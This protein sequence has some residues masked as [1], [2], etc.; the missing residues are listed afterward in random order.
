VIATRADFAEIR[1]SL[2]AFWGERDVAHLHHPMFIEEFGDCALVV[3]DTDGRVAAYLL[4]MV[5]AAKRLGYVHAVAVRED[6]RGHGLGR[7]LYE[8]FSVLALERGCTRIKAITTPGNTESVA[9]HRSMGM[10]ADPV[11]DYSGPGQPRIVFTRELD[12]TRGLAPS[13]LAGATVRVAT[14]ADVDDVLAFWR[15]AAEDSDR[16]A[17]RREAVQ[18]LIARDPDAL[19]LVVA[20][21][22]ILGCVVIGWDG[23][24]AHIYRLAVHPDHRR[25][26]LGRWLLELAEQRLRAGGA[27]RIDAM[28][29]DANTSAHGLWSAAGYTRQQNWSR[30][31]KPL[32]PG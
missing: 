23:W 3:R 29:L 20:S 21:D 11:S 5:V 22:G 10:D 19:L 15:A 32:A 27:I 7:R 6:Q 24:R 2:D 12:A 26:G 8:A 14:L 16:P 17:D 18:R 31:V 9:F 30:W 28:V 1:S 13:P 25:R 4:G